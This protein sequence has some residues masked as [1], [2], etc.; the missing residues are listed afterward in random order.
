MKA[1]SAAVLVSSSCSSPSSL[2]SPSNSGNATQQYTRI[3]NMQV[4]RSGVNCKKIKLYFLYH[5]NIQL[6]T[7]LMALLQ[8]RPN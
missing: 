6:N 4:V 5:S 2:N 8:I 3:K 1:C 7:I